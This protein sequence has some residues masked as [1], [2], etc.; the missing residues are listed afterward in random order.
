MSGA[1]A[2]RYHFLG[3]AAAQGAA[4]IPDDAPGATRAEIAIEPAC[5]QVEITITENDAAGSTRCV[6]RVGCDVSLWAGAGSLPYVARVV[7][8]WP[9]D[10]KNGGGVL[11]V[12]WYYR[13]TELP[14]DL[15]ED[16]VR[17]SGDTGG[18]GGG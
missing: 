5:E 17:V 6:V 16:L 13:A 12:R 18:E 14:G 1:R 15:V 3:P 7:A 9:D 10:S 8:L 4:Q 2:Y 11:R